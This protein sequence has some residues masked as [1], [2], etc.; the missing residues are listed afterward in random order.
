MLSSFIATII[1]LNPTIGSNWKFYLEF[2]GILLY[3]E[4]KV[5]VNQ[6]SGMPYDIGQNRLYEFCYLLSYDL[7]FLF[8]KDPF[9]TR[10]C[11]V[12]QWLVLKSAFSLRLYIIILH[13][14]Y[15]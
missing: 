10:M 2:P 11:D 15:H 5:Q 6:S 13:L 9:S 8:S 3:I 14:K 7:E 12:D 4:V 1:I